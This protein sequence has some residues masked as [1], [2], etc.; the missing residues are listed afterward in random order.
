MSRHFELLN[1]SEHGTVVD[2]VVYCC[3]I[4]I[5]ETKTDTDDVKEK[6]KKQSYKGL[7]D[8]LRRNGDTTFPPFFEQKEAFIFNFLTKFYFHLHNSQFFV[9]PCSLRDVDAG[10]KSLQ[11]DLLSLAEEREVVGK[12][13]HYLLMVLT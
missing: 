3:D 9:P 6:E 2:N 11:S 1:Y 4:G 12:A 13:L 10:L 7:D 8:T 5:E